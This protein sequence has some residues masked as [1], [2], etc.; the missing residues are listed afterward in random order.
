MD[1]PRKIMMRRRADEN[2]ARGRKQV[3]ITPVPNSGA[4]KMRDRY[5]HGTRFVANLPIV[6]L[7]VAQ[8]FLCAG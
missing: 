3:H 8:F 5:N 6:P 7:C 2:R 4:T 1:S